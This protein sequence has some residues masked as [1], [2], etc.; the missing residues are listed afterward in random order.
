MRVLSSSCARLEL[1]SGREV[2]RRAVLNR[3]VIADAVLAERLDYPL[4]SVAVAGHGEQRDLLEQRGDLADSGTRIEG[5]FDLQDPVEHHRVVFEV[6]DGS[7][8]G[9]FGAAARISESDIALA[10]EIAAL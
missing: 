6:R 5:G 7:G 1:S 8:E 4:A 9:I 3:V 10:G 2:D